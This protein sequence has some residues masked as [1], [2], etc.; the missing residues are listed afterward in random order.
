MYLDLE[1]YRPDTPHLPQSISLREG[2]LASLL[3]HALMVIAYL[4]TPASTPQE[5]SAVSQ[6]PA[7][8]PIQFVHMVPTLERPAPPRPNPEHSDLDRRA[9]S[10]ERPPD[11]TNMK[12]VL[13]W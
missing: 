11:A 9:A 7:R 5:A 10:P 3:A 4:V 1:D 13:G 12:P 8:E 6:A 2:I